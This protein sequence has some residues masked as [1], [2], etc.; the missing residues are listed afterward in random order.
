LIRLPR[1]ETKTFTRKVR[2]ILFLAGL[3]TR[4]LIFRAS[5]D[6]ELP[7]KT[8]LSNVPTLTTFTWNHRD[9]IEGKFLLDSELDPYSGNSFHG[10]PHVLFIYSTLSHPWLIFAALTL[11]D[12]VTSL[13]FEFICATFQAFLLKTGDFATLISSDGLTSAMLSPDSSDFPRVLGVAF[14]LNPFSM[15]TCA[16]LSCVPFTCASI[17]LAITF[18]FSGSPVLCGI[19][20]AISGLLD[21]YPIYFTVPIIYFYFCERH[22]K[23]IILFLSSLSITLYIGLYFAHDFTGGWTFLEKFFLYLFASKDFRPNIGNYWYMMQLIFHRFVPL[24]SVVFHSLSAS[25]VIPFLVSF[26][27]YQLL[28]F[29][30]ISILYQLLRAAPTLGDHVHSFALVLCCVEIYRGTTF[31][32][33]HVFGLIFVLTTTHTM[34]YNWMNRNGNANFFYFQVLIY[35]IIL[36]HF[37]SEVI[38][39]SR[40][41]DFR[42]NRV[43]KAVESKKE[44]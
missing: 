44:Q 21:F 41:R 23:R 8:S 20:V 26:Q 25:F 7:E 5:Y 3:I 11:A 16:A 35:N 24:F 31:V 15:V 40:N 18:F 27:K 19:F 30:T 10:S 6:Y 29:A 14:W 28:V 9:Y 17:N 36:L 12:L 4:F 34:F 1:M 2:I 13:S 33:I 37:M 42:L 43:S 32:L 38:K 39:R 22:F